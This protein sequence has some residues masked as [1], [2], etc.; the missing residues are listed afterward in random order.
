MAND[1]FNLQHLLDYGLSSE[2]NEEVI[3]IFQS[4]LQSLSEATADQGGG[5]H[6]TPQLH[7][8]ANLYHSSLLSNLDSL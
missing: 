4:A 5:K 2:D 3:I 1:K 6:E 8:Q 7:A